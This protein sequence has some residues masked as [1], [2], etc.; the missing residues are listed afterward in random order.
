MQQSRLQIRTNELYET[1]YSQLEAQNALGLLD[2]FMNL[3]SPRVEGEVYAAYGV[4]TTS[5]MSAKTTS[6][7]LRNGGVLHYTDFGGVDTLDTY[8]NSTQ[9]RAYVGEDADLLEEIGETTISKFI[10]RLI[11]EKVADEKI[12]SIIDGWGLVWKA[13]SKAKVLADKMAAKSVAAADGCAEIISMSAAG[14]TEQGTVMIGWK[15]YPNAVLSDYAT[16]IEGIPLMSA[17]D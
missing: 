1:V 16:D 13:L 9:Y 3:L 8:Y 6:Y 12:L 15:Q 5:T 11:K 17:D 7:N 4:S 10:K 14:G 2:S